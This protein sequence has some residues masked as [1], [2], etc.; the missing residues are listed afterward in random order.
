MKN[1][2]FRLFPASF[3]QSLIRRALRIRPIDD[4]E[5]QFKIA[6]T[7]EELETAYRLLHDCY[8]GVGLMDPHFSGL[9]CT[10][11][12]ALP[13]T[14]TIIAKKGSQV[15]GTVSLIKDSPLGFPS[16]K[17]YR[18]ENDDYRREGR[19]IAEVSALAVHAEFRKDHRISL[20][21]MKYLNWYALHYMGCDMFCIVVHPRARDFY[22]GLFG[23]VQ[24]GKTVKYGFVKGA[25]AAHMT[26]DLKAARER[27]MPELYAGAP[28]ERDLNEFIYRGESP[29]VYPNRG[30]GCVLD[31][32]MTPSMLTYFFVRRTQLFKTLSPAELSLIRSSYN[33][34]FD[35]SGVPYLGQAEDDRR[36]FR[37]PMKLRVALITEGRGLIGRIRDISAGGLFFEGERPLPVGGKCEVLFRLGEQ[38]FRL[39]AVVRWVS[40]GERAGPPGCGMEFLVKDVRLT[41]MLRFIHHNVEIIAEPNLATA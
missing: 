17:E 9:R 3:R 24:N 23:F 15:I 4:P 14:T 16:D 22:A 7:T 12:S 38:Q 28:A 25:L 30:L 11:Y 26:L 37:Y 19:Q 41:E 20:Y 13:Y 34:N 6:T 36:Q 21:L 2:L 1:A 31:P 10:V 18:K 27:I 39:P 29:F 35:L 5:I 32:V 40:S 8:A 33:L